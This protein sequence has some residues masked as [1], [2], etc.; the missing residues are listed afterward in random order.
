MERS[1]SKRALCQ[2]FTFPNNIWSISNSDIPQLLVIWKRCAMFSTLLVKNITTSYFAMCCKQEAKST[3][4]ENSNMS[5]WQPQ[6]E[7]NMMFK[8][9]RRDGNVFKVSIVMYGF[10]YICA[11]VI[12]E[13]RAAATQR[14]QHYQWGKSTRCSKEMERHQVANRIYLKKT[15]FTSIQSSFHFI[16]FNTVFH[17][18]LETCQTWTKTEVD[19]SWSNEDRW[20]KWCT[21]WVNSLWPRDQA[22]LGLYVWQH[23]GVRMISFFF[24]SHWFSVSLKNG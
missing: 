19:W 22:V 12:L 10:N 18:R 13:T 20:G 14:D 5:K 17:I 21:Y 24:N 2:L 1:W 11:F 3:S 15:P 8:R 16:E 9:K 7:R 4:F 6:T 23:V